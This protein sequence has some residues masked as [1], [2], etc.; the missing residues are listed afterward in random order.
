[1]RN[2]NSFSVG[3]V[4]L[5]SMGNNHVRVASNNPYVEKVYAYDK[6]SERLKSLQEK[7]DC[8]AANSF[9]ELV[10]NV[11][12][13]VVATSTLSHYEIALQAISAG[14]HCLIEKPITS[15]V[16]EALNIKK[17]A[18]EAGVIVLIGHVERYNPVFNE[19]S[20][21]L[22][23]EK[24]LAVKSQRLSYNLSRA[25][26][27]SVVLDL[28]IHDID[29]VTKIANSRLEVVSVAGGEYRSPNL[30]YVVALM[31]D[32]DGVTYDLTASKISQTRVRNLFVSCENCFIEADYLKKQIQIFRHASGKY[33]ESL[34][35]IGY[36][37][38][39]LVEKVFVPNVEPLMSEHNDLY[40]SIIN[41]S[42]PKVSID[43]G[44]RSL[45]LCHAVEDKFN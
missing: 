36:K 43:D 12:V 35:K 29:A 34:Q 17:K 40:K 13:V 24:I 38:E 25:N 20:K 45:E 5:G 18:E 33:L 1:M 37:H 3:V 21:I 39:A 28:M 26:D 9:E 7:Y 11:D 6:D 27:V 32:G 4:G 2:S 19:L 42:Q 14:K 15:K 30:D 16:S 31:K 41:G 22:D 44:I 23:N 8:L 10:G